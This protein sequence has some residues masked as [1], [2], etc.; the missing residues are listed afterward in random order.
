MF[1]CQTPPNQGTSSVYHNPPCAR[2]AYKVTFEIVNSFL[3]PRLVSKS[4][5]SIKL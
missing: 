1:C 4:R 3:M 2:K 5:L